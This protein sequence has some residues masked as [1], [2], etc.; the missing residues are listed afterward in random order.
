MCVCVYFV[1]AKCAPAQ[2]HNCVHMLCC[3]VERV[4]SYKG[5]VCQFETFSLFF[6]LSSKRWK[7]W[8]TWERVGGRPRDGYLTMSPQG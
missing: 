2:G 3:V 4:W 7:K 8:R 1:P 6:P 5:H